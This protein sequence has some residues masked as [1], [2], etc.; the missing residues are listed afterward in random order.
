MRTLE[1]STNTSELGS[2]SAP[3]KLDPFFRPSSVAVIGASRDPEKLGYAVLANLKNGGF[4]GALYPVNPK[5]DEILG[6]RAYPTVLDIPGPVDL[7]L[8]VIPYPLVPAALEQCGQ[9]GIPAAV[10]ISAGFREA[11]REGL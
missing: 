5:A 6:L 4:S 1:T 2:G 8:I 10:I 9:K 11:G 3:H 7:A